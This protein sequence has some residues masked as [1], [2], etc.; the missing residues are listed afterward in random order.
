MRRLVRMLVWLPYVC[1]CANLS[2]LTGGT[3]AGADASHV[4]DADAGGSNDAQPE[5][6]GA[7][8]EGGEAMADASLES[9]SVDAGPCAVVYVAAASGSDLSSGCSPAAP[10][11]TVAAALAA[12]SAVDAGTVEVC[13]G[14]YDENDLKLGSGVSLRGGYDCSTWASTGVPDGGAGSTILRNSSASPSPATLTIVGTAVVQ[15]FAV[16]GPTAPAVDAGTVEPYAAVE[17][18]STLGSATISDNLITGGGGPAA[19]AGILVEQGASAV[20]TGNAI[21]GGSGVSP[22]GSPASAGVLVQ[23]NGGNVVIAGNVVHG[24][25]GSAVG[26]A[27]GAGSSAIYFTPSGTIPAT[28]TATGNTIYGGNGSASCTGVGLSPGPPAVRI[29]PGLVVFS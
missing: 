25:S 4:A 12:A 24:G 20:I 5:A 23:A 17:V 21:N 28:L 22:Y 3:D 26:T 15:G 7:D 18:L 19:S 14:V 27:A 9:S 8:A 2:G 16:Q 13:S 29:R 10:K 6:E 11:Q 1:G